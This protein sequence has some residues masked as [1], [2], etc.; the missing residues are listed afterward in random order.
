VA[1]VAPGIVLTF[2]TVS[3]PLDLEENLRD[4]IVD[5][6]IDW[7]PIELDPFVNSRLFDD[8]MVLVARKNHPRVSP[9]VTIEGLRKEEFISLH[10]RRGSDNMPQALKELHD[11]Q[12]HEGMY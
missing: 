5:V 7:L 4:G 3:R 9:R 12:F 10:H 6:A 1:A 11:L 2:D 8:R